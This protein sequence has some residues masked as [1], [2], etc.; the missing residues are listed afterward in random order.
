MLGWVGSCVNSG[1][2]SDGAW[3]LVEVVSSVAWLGVDCSESSDM[4]RCEDVF[5][6][7]LARWVCPFTGAMCSCPDVDAVEV[8]SRSVEP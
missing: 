6:W 4:W 8:A 3:L 7:P 5:V 2:V 1:W